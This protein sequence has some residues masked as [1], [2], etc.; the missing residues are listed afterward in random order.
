VSLRARRIASDEA[1]AWARNLRLGN[2][3]AKLILC[4][5]TLYVD[6]EGCC[7]VSIPTLAEDCELSVDTVRSRLKWLES[8]GVISRTPQ[9]ID[10]SGRRN[11]VGPGQRTSDTIKLIMTGIGPSCELGAPG[12]DAGS[13]PSQQQGPSPGCQQGA[14]RLALGQPLIC[15]KD[16]IS[17]NLNLNKDTQLI[18]V[19][20][21]GALAAWDEYGR[22]TPGKT[23]PRNRRGGW[24]FPSLWPPGH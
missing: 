11:S 3:F 6:G 1:H 22:R 14:P 24:R 7:F 18:E 10:A 4:M 5:I 8:I 16:L 2:P 17:S 12:S 20:D 23:Y 9:W 19:K 15:G 21:E 13:S